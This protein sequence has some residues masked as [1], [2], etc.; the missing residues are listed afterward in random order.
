MSYF[1]LTKFQVCLI[2]FVIFVSTSII[3]VKIFQKVP[4]G[5]VNITSSFSKIDRLKF[6]VYN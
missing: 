6:N 4:S 1:I 5:C 3:L 2:I